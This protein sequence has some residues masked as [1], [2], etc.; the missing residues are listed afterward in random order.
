MVIDPAKDTGGG[1]IGPNTQLNYVMAGLYGFFI[2]VFIVF[3]RVF[4]D[5]KIRDIKQLEKI[6]PIPVLGMVGKSKGDSNLAVLDSPKSAISEAFR[7]LR[8][9][10][11]FLYKE[12]GVVGSKTVLIT[13]SI[14]G[15][16]KSFCAINLASVFALSD[17]KAVIVDL[18]LR[19]PKVSK[20]IN[21]DNTVGVVDFLINRSEEHTSEL[22][23]RPHLVCRLLLEKKKKKLEIYSISAISKTFRHL[24]YLLILYY[25]DKLKLLPHF[26]T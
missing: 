5:T 2:P 10:L 6:T 1:K 23:S 26:Y 19:K 22:Q 20:Y 18:D 13:S 21:I 16:G 8:S 24:R 25:L 11:Q 15:E 4:F 7:N 17:K 9:S 3:A 12:R 14:S